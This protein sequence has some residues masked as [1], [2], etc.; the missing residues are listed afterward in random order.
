MSKNTNGTKFTNGTNRIQKH[1]KNNILYLVFDKNENLITI[2]K[3]KS[4]H[5]KKKNINVV[6]NIIDSI[7]IDES[8]IAFTW[9]KYS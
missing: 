6:E 4:K 9:L 5:S 3:T 2:Q 8:F 1:Q 7:H